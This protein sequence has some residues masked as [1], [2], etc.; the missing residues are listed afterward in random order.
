MSPLSEGD[1]A[2]TT[3]REIGIIE[4]LLESGE[5]VIRV[6]STVGW[7][8]PSWKVLATAELTKCN[9]PRLTSTQQEEL[10]VKTELE[11]LGRGLF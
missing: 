8:F 9:K 10:H 5:A 1:W 3:A 6:P 2:T 4:K 11:N 7:P